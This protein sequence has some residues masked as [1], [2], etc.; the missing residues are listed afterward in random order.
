MNI[1]NFVENSA[2]RQKN[3][4]DK[5]KART[6]KCKNI[7]KYADKQ[8]TIYNKCSNKMLYGV[9]NKMAAFGVSDG[10]SDQL[11]QLLVLKSHQLGAG[12][13]GANPCV[14]EKFETNKTN[15]AN[16]FKITENVVISLLVFIMFF[17]IFNRNSI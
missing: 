17:M 12:A 8:N 13:A 7:E 10:T 9:N 16:N 5:I 3:F 4:E 14:L 15:D 6:V 11:D 1:D 2:I